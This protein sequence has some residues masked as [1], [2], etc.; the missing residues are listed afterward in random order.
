MLTRGTVFIHDTFLD[1][2]WAP[3]QGQTYARSPKATMKVLKV[4]THTVWY[5]Y[6]WATRS[7]WR[8]ARKDFE[9]RFPDSL[10]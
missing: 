9:N 6:V 1:P 8:L 2:D 3:G 10:A 7:G 5:G 4:D